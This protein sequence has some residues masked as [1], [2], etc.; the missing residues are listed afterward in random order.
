MSQVTSAPGRPRLSVLKGGDPLYHSGRHTR[1]WFAVWNVRGD[2]RI[3]CTPA[4]M[5]TDEPERMRGKPFSALRDSHPDNTAI[6]Y[7]G[8]YAAW[9]DY[10]PETSCFR[11]VSRWVP[12]DGNDVVK[13]IAGMYVPEERPK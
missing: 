10:F 11:Q 3:V 6:P 7:F 2:Q 13:L 4:P 9:F 5:N 12:L 8:I 1:I